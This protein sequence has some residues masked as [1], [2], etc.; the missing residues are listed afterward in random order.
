MLITIA[1]P[2][3]GSLITKTLGKHQNRAPSHAGK[4]FTQEQ[5]KTGCR[6]GHVHKTAG[7]Y[8]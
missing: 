2:Y 6:T 1:C 5:S 4:H 3:L 8:T 7:D